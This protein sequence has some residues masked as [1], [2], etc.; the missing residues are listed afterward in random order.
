[1]LSLQVTLF[2]FR[3]SSPSVSMFSGRDRISPQAVQ[4]EP[5]TSKF[6]QFSLFA[7][8][9][10]VSESFQESFFWQTIHFILNDVDNRSIQYAPCL[11]VHHFVLQTFWSCPSTLVSGVRPLRNR[12]EVVAPRRH[13]AQ[14]VDERHPV[15]SY[16]ISLSLSLSLSLSFC[17]SDCM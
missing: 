16:S 10:T 13:R 8:I 2:F 9:M 4:G 6:R 14:A 3:N 5:F 7:L 15:C 12:S 17:L 11:N 1:M